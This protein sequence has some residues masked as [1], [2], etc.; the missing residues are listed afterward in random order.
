MPGAAPEPS[1]TRLLTKAPRGDM[2]PLAKSLWAL[3]FA[4]TRHFWGQSCVKPTARESEL[5]GVEFA[6]G[7]CRA[8]ERQRWGITN[9][10]IIGPIAAPAASV[11]TARRSALNASQELHFRCLRPSL[12]CRFCHL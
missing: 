6:R 11:Q 8:E 12:S 9:V 2:I 10:R 1:T 7:A 3:G 5:L 4:G